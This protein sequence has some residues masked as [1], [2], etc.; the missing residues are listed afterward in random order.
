MATNQKF[1]IGIIAGIL[2]LI[3]ILVFAFLYFLDAV[4][5]STDPRC[6]GEKL[7]IVGD[8]SRVVDGDTIYVQ[9]YKI[10]L[11]LVD[12]PETNEPGFQEATD[13][14]RNLCPVGSRVVVDQDDK[15]PFD[16]YD[17]VLG[18]VFCGDKI[19]S[20]ELLN[21]GHASMSTQYC[22]T[23]EFANDSWAKQHGC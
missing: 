20:E 18:K 16:K 23:S 9:T 5:Y 3:G 7:C 2:V 17:R 11:A 8:V 14:T 22:S 4:F 1:A 6:S 19:L 21:S 15:Q 13:F 10:R 12:T